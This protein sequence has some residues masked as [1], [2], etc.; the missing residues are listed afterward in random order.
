MF[1]PSIVPA[2][3]PRSTSLRKSIEATVRQ[4]SFEIHPQIT[5]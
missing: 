5:E 4:R 3:V 2:D 1:D